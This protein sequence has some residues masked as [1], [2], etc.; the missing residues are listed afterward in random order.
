MEVEVVKEVVVTKDV[1]KNLGI[2]VAS[3]ALAITAMNVNS[4]CIF[5]I[6]QPKLPK[7]ASKLRKF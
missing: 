2:L 5:V 7:D 6:H 1:I 3:T 4:A